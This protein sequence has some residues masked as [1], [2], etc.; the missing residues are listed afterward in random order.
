MADERQ[1]QPQS[2]SKTEAIGRLRQ[3]IQRLEAVVNQLNTEAN[4]TLPSVTALDALTTDVESLATTL[5]VPAFTPIPVVTEDDFGEI[6]D[7]TLPPEE[8]KLS[9]IDRILPTFDRV[10]DTWD[11][12]LDRV[13]RFLPA[14]LNQRLSDWAL[15]GVLA[16]TI[17]AILSTSV[18]LTAIDDT[19]TASEPPEIADLPVSPPPVAVPEPE[20]VSPPSEGVEPPPEDFAETEP[21]EVPAVVE[22]PETPE[23]A[24]PVVS[25]PPPVVVLTPEQRLVASIQNRVAQITG[26]YAEGLIDTVEA[27]F[28]AGRLSIKL[29]EDWYGLPTAQQ[30]RIANQMWARSQDL[31]FTKLELLD[32]KG[33]L[34]ARS[35]VVGEEMVILRRTPF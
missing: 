34:L 31:D 6:A 5:E 8:A 24:A 2:L 20:A 9:F 29:V 15:T 7:E 27:N 32:P 26:Q 35:P 18:I 28:L 10:Q 22:A 3:T 25:E 12:V 4:E 30:N 16:T 23:P 21:P 1:D 33:N 17:V 19:E 14:A 13:R 11:W